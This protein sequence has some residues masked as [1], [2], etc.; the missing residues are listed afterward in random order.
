MRKKMALLLAG[1]LAMSAMGGCVVYPPGSAS[2]A[3]RHVDKLEAKLE[4]GMD[5]LG[6]QL[7]DLEDWPEVADRLRKVEIYDAKTDRL[8]GTLEDSA[9]LRDFEEAVSD[10][11]GRRYNSLRDLERVFSEPKGLEREYRFEAY[12]ASVGKL[13]RDR[14]YQVLVIT[15]YKDSPIVYL[16]IGPEMIPVLNS[17]VTFNIELRQS[18]MDMLR[19]LAETAK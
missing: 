14:L 13:D 5:K 6:E 7:H 4:R 10:E 2:R 8:L 11:V 17:L 1:L 15:T 12:S 19:N 9:Q 3:R 16:E 18:Q